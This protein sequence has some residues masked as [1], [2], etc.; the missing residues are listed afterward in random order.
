MDQRAGLVR[1]TKWIVVSF[2]HRSMHPHKARA[3]RKNPATLIMEMIMMPYLK[4]FTLALPVA[5]AMLSFGGTAGPAHAKKMTCSQKYHGCQVRC[6]RSAG[7]GPV[8]PCIQRTC[9][10]QY[11]N[12]V[13]K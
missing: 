5:L 11:D 7:D 2:A 12:C 3:G 4:A 8:G 6:F 9:D 10:R 13:G 1:N